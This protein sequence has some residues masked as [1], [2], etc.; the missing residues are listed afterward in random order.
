MTTTPAYH[1]LPPMSSPST[2]AMLTGLSVTRIRRCI[3]ST[4]TDRY[5]W[6]PLP[7]VRLP[8]GQLRITATA[9][10]AWIDSLPTT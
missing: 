7:A 3:N 9:G 6:P 2:F 5:G 1:G 4:E 8:D 10:A